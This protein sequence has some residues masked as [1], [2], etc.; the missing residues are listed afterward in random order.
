MNPSDATKYL[1]RQFK[2]RMDD[3]GGSTC[4][5]CLKDKPEQEIKL[6]AVFIRHAP[7][8]SGKRRAVAYCVCEI[9]WEIPE[10]ECLRRVELNLTCKGI[11]MQSGSEG[12]A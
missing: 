9:C 1:V 5:C 6:I 10:V 11:Y 2:E 4:A 7:A 12:I 3:M 8:I